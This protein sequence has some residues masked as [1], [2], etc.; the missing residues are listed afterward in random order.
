MLVRTV[1]YTLDDGD[2]LTA[3]SDT[4]H[5]RGQTASGI[6]A[7]LVARPGKLAGVPRPGA[8][9]LHNGLR[10]AM[11]HAG[12]RRL[13]CKFA[14]HGIE[15]IGRPRRRHTGRTVRRQPLQQAVHG[16]AQAA[17]QRI[18]RFRAIFSRYQFRSCLRNIHEG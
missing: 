3:W 4:D 10:H 5:P 1:R 15:L 12:L 11:G 16:L 18:L 14:G 13:Q 7:H 9:A 8:L 2:N 6:D 17:L